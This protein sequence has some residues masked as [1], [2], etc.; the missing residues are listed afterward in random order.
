MAALTTNE[1][2][3][4]WRAMANKIV[5]TGS[6]KFTKDE[7]RTAADAAQT[8]ADANAASFNTALTTNAAS[9]ASKATSQEKA[10]LLAYICLNRAGLL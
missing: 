1:K 10:L 8:W 7:L 3:A 5:E 2:T 4:I 6:M 9:F